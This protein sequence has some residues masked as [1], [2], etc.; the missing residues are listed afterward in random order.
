MTHN[1]QDGTIAAVGQLSPEDEQLV[2]A[3]TRRD[4]QG[5]GDPCPYSVRI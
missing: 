2:A 5:H 1:Q 3:M 4:R